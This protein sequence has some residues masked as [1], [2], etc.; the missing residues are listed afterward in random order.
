MQTGALQA[1]RDEGLR[2]LSTSNAP[3][4]LSAEVAALIDQTRDAMAQLD[5]GRAKRPRTR[6]RRTLSRS[7]TQTAL[8]LA[9]AFLA[10]AGLDALGACSR[11]MKKLAG[12]ECLWNALTA[13]RF[14][15]AAHLREVGGACALAG[16]REYRR[17]E[18][19]WN[20]EP[21]EYGATPQINAYSALVVM[22]HFDRTLING[23]FAMTK[24]NRNEFM[25][26]VA[27]PPSFSD[28]RVRI[29]LPEGREA[30]SGL[31]VSV[32]LIRKHDGKVRHLVDNAVPDGNNIEGQDFVFVMPV[33][34]MKNTARLPTL[35]LNSEFVEQS[36]SNWTGHHMNHVYCNIERPSFDE[37]G[38][39]LVSFN[40][41]SIA[42]E[43]VAG[44]SAFAARATTRAILEAWRF[45]HDQDDGWI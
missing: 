2:L 28:C 24:H 15:E 45:S 13:R 9:S 4:A 6:S 11:A 41:I 7:A 42:Y 30:G 34:L 5:D 1:W 31:S 40:G 29:D 43:G 22:K 44:E 39:V 10:P 36:H 37:T 12:S 21:Y 8:N 32:F 33:D 23:I 14:P 25:I 3:A 20:P 38:G 27:S 19:L 16:R 26:D 18:R 17:M 35:C